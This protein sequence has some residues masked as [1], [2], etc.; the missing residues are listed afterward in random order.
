ME[1]SGGCMS[2]YD[3][4]KQKINKPKFFF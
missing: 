2:Q 3:N 1:W 4:Y